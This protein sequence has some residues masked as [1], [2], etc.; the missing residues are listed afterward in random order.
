MLLVLVYSHIV[1]SSH[2]PSRLRVSYFNYK[3]HK[4]IEM[5]KRNRYLNTVEVDWKVI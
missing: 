1:R 5:I 4:V 3:T 2:S